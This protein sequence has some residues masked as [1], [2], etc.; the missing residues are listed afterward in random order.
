MKNKI[1][2]ESKPLDGGA[3][4]N[5]AAELKLE[6]VV[7]AMATSDQWT[8]GPAQ[9]HLDF[10]WDKDSEIVTTFF[11]ASNNESAV[12]VVASITKTQVYK[13]QIHAGLWETRNY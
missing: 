5:D 13:N 9:H 7:K 10:S 4:F 2:I 8:K 12:K 11:F 3:L 1:L 6:Q